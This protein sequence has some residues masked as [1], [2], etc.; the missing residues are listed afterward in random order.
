MKDRE[1]H[2]GPGAVSLLLVIV[3]VSMSVLGLLSL[4]SARGDY[5]LTERA[6]TLA[7]AENT[8]SAQSEADLAALDALLAGAE[9][10]AQDEED[11]LARVGASL[12]ENMC[13]NERVV[14][15]EQASP[16]GRTLYC[17]AE[18]AP[19]GELPRVGWKMHMFAAE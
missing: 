15:W 2:I 17:E 11:Y 8:A 5:K 12:P 4:I 14:S 7:V 18:I 6:V 9:A 19:M 16:G 3:V 1:Y 10:D 13:L